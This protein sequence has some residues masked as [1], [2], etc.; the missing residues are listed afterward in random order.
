MVGGVFISYTDLE[1]THDEHTQVHSL[2]SSRPPRFHYLL[3]SPPYYLAPSHTLEVSN[4]ILARLH[5]RSHIPI[6]DQTRP[7]HAPDARNITL[8]LRDAVAPEVDGPKGC[9]GQVGAD[10]DALEVDGA[11]FELGGLEG[12][13]DG[14]AVLLGWDVSCHVLSFEEEEDIAASV[15]RGRRKQADTLAVGRSLGTS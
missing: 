12:D 6:L 5:S 2:L 7:D 10:E 11:A 8:A 4:R 9:A 13:H 14:D 3:T 1:S 15:V